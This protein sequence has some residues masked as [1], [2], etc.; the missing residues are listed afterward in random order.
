MTRIRIRFVARLPST[1]GPIRAAGCAT[2]PGF[3]GCAERH[4]QRQ[5]HGGTM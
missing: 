1:G 5:V 3:K 4:R 2:T